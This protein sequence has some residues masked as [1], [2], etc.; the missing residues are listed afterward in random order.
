MV[1]VLF[2]ESNNTNEN[3]RMEENIMKKKYIIALV[4]TVVFMGAAAGLALNASGQQDVPANTNESSDMSTLPSLTV[5]DISVSPI[6]SNPTQDTESAANGQSNAN[7]S[8]VT[9]TDLTSLPSKPTSAPPPPTIE[10]AGGVDSNGNPIK[11]TNP[12]LLDKDNPPSYTSQPVID[13]GSKPSP[14]S[15]GISSKP[16][17]NNS[18]SKPNNNSG[19]NSSKPSSNPS[20]PTPSTPN[21]G[22]TKDGK[23]Y[24][25]GF[26]W[27]EGTG[28]GKGEVMEGA[29]GTGEQI[30]IME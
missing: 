2:G 1:I 11:A 29:P 16:S 25:P 30:G 28:G 15:P 13:G 19:S 27:V 9:N 3:Q 18:S 10:G 6:Q 5:G 26:G 4:A 20:K 8:V 17:S 22:D 7:K 23:S 14:S 12:A 24:M 21:A